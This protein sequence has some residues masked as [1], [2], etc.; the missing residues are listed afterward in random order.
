M[1]KAVREGTLASVRGGP[2]QRLSGN[3]SVSQAGI[4]S[5]SSQRGNAIGARQ[6]SQSMGAPASATGH[7]RLAYPV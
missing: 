3:A 6:E 7:N 4:D 1:V 5:K 2:A